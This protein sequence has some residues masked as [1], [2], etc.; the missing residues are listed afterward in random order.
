MSFENG[1]SFYAKPI[2][3]KRGYN[4]E[5]NAFLLLEN[6][7]AHSINWF[8]AI[9]PLLLPRSYFDDTFLSKSPSRKFSIAF[10]SRKRLEA[11]RLS[12]KRTPPSRNILMGIFSCSN[13][14]HTNKSSEICP[15]ERPFFHWIHLV[16]CY[17]GGNF[18]FAPMAEI[19]HIYKIAR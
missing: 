15:W 8:F 16:W 14:Y 1:A 13:Q 4:S 2:L 3:W 10:D 7:V 9:L 12:F 17:R 19:S 5:R 18:L 11:L 6:T